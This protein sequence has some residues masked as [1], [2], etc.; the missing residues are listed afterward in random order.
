M[1]GSD[2][3]RGAEKEAVRGTSAAGQAGGRSDGARH[4]FRAYGRPAKIAA[5]PGS[6]ARGDSHHRRF[7]GDDRR[8]Q[9]PVGDASATDPRSR[10]GQRQDVSGAGFQG[11]GSG[12]DEGCVQRRVVPEDDLHRGDQAEQP[13]DFA[14]DAAAGRFSRAHGEVTSDPGARVAISDHA[15]LGFGGHPSRCGTGGDRSAFQHHGRPRSAERGKTGGAGGDD[16]ADPRGARRHA[17]DEQEPRQRDRGER[18]AGRDV[19]Q[20][21]EHFG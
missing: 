10:A 15:G 13:G 14:A 4:P 8:S 9:R 12:Q 1:R 5:V 7:H 18:G 3:P 20:G 2:Q 16:A 6:G 19:R 21:D 17:E 11:V